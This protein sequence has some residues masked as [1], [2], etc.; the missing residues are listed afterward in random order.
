MHSI[1]SFAKEFIVNI[2]DVITEKEIISLKNSD[3]FAYKQLEDNLL[4]RNSRK[5]YVF[6]LVEALAGVMFFVF[7]VIGNNSD[8]QGNFLKII[9]SVT[10]IFGAVLFFIFYK[11]ELSVRKPDSRRLRIA[12]YVYWNLFTICGFFISAGGY[13]DNKNI[14]PFLIF[15][16]IVGI[17]PVFR[18][19]ENLVAACIYLVPCIYYGVTEKCGVLFYISVSV[20]LCSFVWFN[21]LKLQYYA[22]RW[23]GKRKLKEATDRC[24]N[25]SQTDNLTGMLNRTGLST[26]FRERYSDSGEVH[27]IA[28]IMADVDNFRL[29][30][31][32]YGFDRSDS[33]L[34]NI[35]NCIRI[36]SKPVT[37]IVARF[38]GDDFILVTEDMNELEVMRFAEQLRSAIE[39]M[40]VPFGEKGVVTI[41]IGISTISEFENE[42]TYSKL[43]N[44]ADLQ[45]MIA[46]N[47]GKNCIGYRNRPFI[48]ESRKTQ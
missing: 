22:E 29:Y 42:D 4:L 40:A 18:I 32:K 10:L 20:A 13:H 38:G 27:K 46:K 43:I 5:C 30:N 31:H 47:S 44:E 35:C 48:Q 16:V 6:T 17:V 8:A 9:G 12:F 37:D 26:K 36:I 41:S 28:V 45:L 3:E 1:A 11:S 2:K 25:I 33:C 23:V 34:Y 24:F 7:S 39:T 15:V 19:A 21:S 14:F